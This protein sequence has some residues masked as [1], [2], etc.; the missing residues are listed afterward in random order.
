MQ[1]RLTSRIQIFTKVRRR[2][3]IKIILLDGKDALQTNVNT[4]LL[5][6]KL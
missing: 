4:R 1:Y 2:I 3:V 6:E 5:Y